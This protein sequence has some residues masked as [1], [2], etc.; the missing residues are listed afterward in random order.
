[1]PKNDKSTATQAVE[2]AA[3]LG[4]GV[5][6][7]IAKSETIPFMKRKVSGNE[8]R[9]EVDTVMKSRDY[10]KM[11]ALAEKYGYDTLNDTMGRIMTPKNGG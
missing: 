10:E 5:I 11:L 2:M 8:I 9:R 7:H 3:E 6:E 1:M 4:A